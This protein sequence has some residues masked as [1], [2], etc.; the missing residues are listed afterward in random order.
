MISLFTKGVSEV[1][2]EGTSTWGGLIIKMRILEGEHQLLLGGG[3]SQVR[4]ESSRMG[5]V[6]QSVMVDLEVGIFQV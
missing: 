2:G 4:V 5:Q 3:R 1:V 6:S